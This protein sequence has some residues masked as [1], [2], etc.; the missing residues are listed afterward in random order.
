MNPK[1]PLKFDWVSYSVVREAAHNAWYPDI[2]SAEKIG[3]ASLFLIEAM[4]LNLVICIPFMIL[5]FHG[6]VEFNTVQKVNQFFIN[7]EKTTI[8]MI[9]LEPSSMRAKDKKKNIV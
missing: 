7:C 3:I 1:M 6:S 4:G 2:M 8:S 5:L 9:I